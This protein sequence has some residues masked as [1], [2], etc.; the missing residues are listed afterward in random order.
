M[1]DFG[2]SQTY[3][4]AFTDLYIQIVHAASQ[5]DHARCLELSRQIGFLNGQENRQM[6]KAHGDSVL[7]VGAPFREKGEF[8]WGSQDMTHKV[9]KLMP[10]MLKN[11]L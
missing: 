7:A 6:T 4:R 1:M 10:V 5:N 2:A 11:R 8:D 3:P 9:Y